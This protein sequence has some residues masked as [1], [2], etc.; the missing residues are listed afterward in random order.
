M[1]A[2]SSPS[3]SPP[4]AVVTGA[5]TGIGRVT[6]MELARRG[7]EVV[8][9]CRNEERTKPVL[10]A[11]AREGRTARFVALDLGDLGSVRTS[12]QRL[13]DAEPRLDVLVNNAGLAGQRGETVDGFELAFG[14]NHVGP[15]LWTRLLLPKVLESKDGRV[16]NVSSKAHYRAPG[17]DY[18]R[19]RGRT[20]SMTGLVEYAHSKL[21]NVLFTQELAERHPADQLLTFAVHPGVVASDIWRRIPGPVRWWMKRGMISNEEGAQGSL[22]LATAAQL[23]AHHGAYF[24]QTQTKTP[25]RVTEDANH[26]RTLWER[27]SDWTELPS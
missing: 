27:T 26:R 24:D 4:V 16:I 10:D 12:A 3:P 17:I 21:A 13:L 1:S 25:N 2:A 23:N 5:N 20:R 9:A 6:A 11:L 8:L 14:V 7:Y 22:H 15:F 19:V 18:T